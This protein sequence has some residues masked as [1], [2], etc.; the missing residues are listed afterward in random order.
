[1]SL[2]ESLRIAGRKTARQGYVLG[3]ELDLACAQIDFFADALKQFG[4]RT[5]ADDAK[6]LAALLIQSNNMGTRLGPALRASSEQLASNPRLRAKELAQ[7]AAN[8][9]RVPLVLLIMPAMIIS[10]LGPALLSA[11]GV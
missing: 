9:M 7:K 8:K 6:S 5:G 11:I 1:L 2:N 10:I 3:A 4:E